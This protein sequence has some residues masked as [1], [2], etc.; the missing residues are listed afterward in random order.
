MISGLRI[1]SHTLALPALFLS[2]VT[3]ALAQA[4]PGDRYYHGPGM[5]WDGGYGS[6]FGMIFGLLFM[7]ILLAALVVA[8]VL[9]LRAFGVLGATTRTDN[10]G[11]ALDILKERFARGEI[12]AEEFDQRKRLLS[13]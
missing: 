10:A 9:V 12:D 4:G 1:V 11:K 3:G 6:G 7:L 8:V 5:M 13:N 2:G